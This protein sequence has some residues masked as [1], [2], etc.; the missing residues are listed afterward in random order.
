MNW[1]IYGVGPQGEAL[2]IAAADLS[3]AASYGVGGVQ[4]FLARTYP[5]RYGTPEINLHHNLSE[6]GRIQVSYG[7][8]L[9]DATFG[10][11]WLPFE[12][13]DFR[14]GIFFRVWP[15]PNDP[16]GYIMLS[17]RAQTF[18]H[19]WER[20]GAQAVAVALS[21]RC[22]R[23]LRPSPDVGGRGG[24]D[25]DKAESTYNQQLGMEYAHD[26]ATGELLGE[27]EYRLG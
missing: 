15:I 26:A 4:G 1:G 13:P 21:I 3:M 8:P 24:T 16:G 27:S 10:Y 9:W 23:Q 11:T 19:L 17:R 22:T 14:G 20:Q 6:S 5:Q 18:K 12:L 7:Q 25:D 2:D